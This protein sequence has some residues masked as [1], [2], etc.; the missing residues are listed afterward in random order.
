MAE[1]GKVAE[2]LVSGLH[3]RIAEVLAPLVPG[4]FFEGCVL[5]AAPDKMRHLLAGA[6][7]ERPI[8]L[9]FALLFAFIFGA[10]CVIWVRMLN[11]FVRIALFQFRKK[12][13]DL[14]EHS[15]LPWAN[16]R[17]VKV[18]QKITSG[19]RPRRPM[20]V[21]FIRRQWARKI[22][23]QEENGRLRAAWFE[24]ASATLKRY[25]V[26]F[27]EEGLHGW[28]CALGKF[29]PEQQRGNTFT[30]ALHG[31][32]WA[33]L[34]ATLCAPPLNVPGF[35][36]LCFFLIMA[37][38]LHILSLASW[39]TDPALSWVLVLRNTWDEHV[40]SGP[41]SAPPRSEVRASDVP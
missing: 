6:G 37:G 8:E 34:V 3:P 31:A 18:N 40:K 26:E 33:G 21:R 2:L 22:K 13:G 29:T 14:L 24:A 20:A 16:S 7:L 27:R 19:V 11:A 9:L 15:L 39:T 23:K 38:L 12:W 1:Y 4:I 10:A 41:L 36:Y 35:R 32:G 30:S 25:G 17:E 5:T 28:S